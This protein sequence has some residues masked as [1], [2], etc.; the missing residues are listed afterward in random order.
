M[1]ALPETSQGAFATSGLTLLEESAAA[2]DAA[3]VGP[4]LMDAAGTRDFVAGLLPLL[5][6]TPVVLDA[7]AMEIVR[8]EEPLAQPVLLTPHAGE[9]AHLS[10]M[11]KEA[12]LKDPQ[13]AAAGAARQWQGLVALKGASTVIAQP[14]GTLWQ[15]DGG[16]P[17]LATSGSGD[18][19]SGLVAGLAAQQVALEQASAWAVVLHAL[20][21]AALARRIGTIGYLA[22]ELPGEIPA[23]IRN[24]QRR[25]RLRPKRRPPRE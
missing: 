12:V 9:M 10:G 15:H 20:A 14:G 1:I 7:L 16:H 23:L 8:R 11:S 5:T 2:T 4:G 21:G 17:G 24:L 3:L 18:V 22:R 25:G 6:Q 13:R 19:L